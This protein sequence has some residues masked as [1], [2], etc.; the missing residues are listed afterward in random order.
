MKLMVHGN[1]FENSIPP[2][3]YFK[4]NSSWASGFDSI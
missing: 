3:R 4:N 2:R 1:R